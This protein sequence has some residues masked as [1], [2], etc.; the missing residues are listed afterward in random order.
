MKKPLILETKLMPPDCS[1]MLPR[2]RLVDDFRQNDVRVTLLCAD[3]GYGKTTLMGQFYKSLDGKQGVWYQLGVG[4]KNMA[5]FLAHLVEGVSWHLPEF[6][7]AMEKAVPD[8]LDADG[9]WETFLTAFI[10]ELSAASD[11]LFVFFFDEFQL[12]NDFENIQEAVQFLITY[13]PPGYRVVLAS[14]ERTSLSLGR[15]RTQRKLKEIDTEDL[16]FTIEEMAGVY[17][18]CCMKE[19]NEDELDVWYAATEGW[20][21]AIVL[22]RNLL[23][24]ERRLPIDV[25]PELLGAHGAIAGYLA[26]EIWSELDDELKQFL[27]ET[28]LLDTVDVGICDQ[29]LMAGKGK[30]SAGL[31]RETEARNLMI[32]CLEEGKS[33]IY[34]PL[35]RQYLKLKLEQVMPVSGVDDLHRRYGQAYTDNGQFDLAIQHFLLSRSPDLAVDIIESR[36][37]A[38]LE[39][40]HYETL[41]KWL[42]QI[43]A[44]I[45]SARPWLAYYSARSSERRGDLEGAERWYEIADKGFTRDSDTFGSFTCAMSIAEFFFMRD[46]HKQCLDKAI[47][48]L[49][50]AATPEQKVA[51]LSRIATQNLLLG[52]GQEAL[53][54]LKQATDLCDRTMVGTRFVLEV[55]ELVPLWFAGEFPALH[56]EAIRLQGVSSPRSPMFARFQILC[57]KVLSFYEMTRYEDALAAIDERSEYLGDEDQLL[58]M[59][60]EFLR[61]VVLLCMGDGKSGREIIEAID[62][63][64]GDTKVLGPFYTPNYLGAYFRRQGELEKAIETNS[65]YLHHRDGGNQYTA[66]SCLVNIGAARIRLKQQ[67]S[68]GIRDLEEAQ[69][70]AV[71]HGYKYISTQAHFN[72]ACDALEKGDEERALEEISEAL[73]LASLYQHNNFIIEE[74][75]IST[76]LIAFA[77]GNGIE[78]EYLVRILPSIGL[79]ALDDLAALLKSDSA[80]VRTA[81]IAA[82]KASGGVAAAPYVRRALRDKDFSVRRAANSELRR[83]RSSIVL[84]EKILTR[85]ENQVME[86]IAEGMS[87]AEIAERLYISEPT[88]KTHI[89]RIFMKLGLTSRSQVAALFQKNIHK[90]G[91]AEAGEDS[92]S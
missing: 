20:P 47:D 45:I 27:M 26:E 83:L 52:F 18:G 59:G 29:A 21:V 66:A 30:S 38:V 31:L 53:K 67:N 56:D 28:S 73:K 5:V 75:R 44:E 41:A 48:S 74:G 68:A 25:N 13:L 3:A 7:S 90:G 10:T 23:T 87:N 1:R 60:F 4:D 92:N 57:W 76:G 6:G 78:Q 64:V 80:Q 24:T 15:L 43:P 22:S 63:E 89:S 12:A 46:M 55:S 35:V 79:A 14:R 11:E 8:A 82:L 37:E 62:R 71:K 42:S 33:Y 70:L 50:S 51:A 61:G 84:P 85:R 17:S 69:A 39:G 49:R 19:L 40:G 16:R 81:A 2:A 9:N 36:G 86:L 65:L 91:D 34:Q 54:T 77:F 58:R 32:S 72:F 88:A